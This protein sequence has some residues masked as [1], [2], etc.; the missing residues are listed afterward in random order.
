M[1]RTRAWFDDSEGVEI[2][3][4]R[5]FHRVVALAKKAKRPRILTLEQ[6]RSWLSLGVGRKEAPV[7]FEIA[8]GSSFHSL[9]DVSREDEYVGYQFAGE[10]SEIP[11]S[12]LISW[13]LAVK[14]ALYYL[15]TGERSPDVVWESDW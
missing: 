3:T 13:D 7:T 6:Q 14:A 4:E 12:F 11:A 2:E 9:G 1:R 10:T 15:E 5:D 8:G